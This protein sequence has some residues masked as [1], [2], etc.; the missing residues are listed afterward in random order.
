LLDEYLAANTTPGGVEP[1]EKLQ[2]LIYAGDV[3]VRLVEDHFTSDL[4]KF[5]SAMP[6][7]RQVALI[8][9]RS[10]MKSAHDHLGKDRTAEALDTYTSARKIF[11][12]NGDAPEA[13][14][15]RYTSAYA[16]LLQSESNESLSDFEYVSREAEAKR[17]RWFLGQSLNGLGN[18]NIGFNNYSLAL[19]LCQ[20]SLKILE[21]VGD[22]VGIVKVNDQLGSVYFRL[23]NRKEAL[24]F[25]HDAIT[26]ATENSLGTGPL[27]RTY[28]LAAVT[29]H[30]VGL[31][32]AGIDLTKESL[33]F[34][35]S[36]NA[37][38]S[39]SRS[40]AQLGVMY[41][42]RGNYPEAASSIERATE[43]GKQVETERVRINAVGYAAL[44]MGNLY[45][46]EGEYSRATESYDEAIRLFDQLNFSAFSYVAHKGKF[47]SCVAQRG[48]CLS[49][50]EELATAL[51]LYEA[52]RSKIVETRNRYSF[53]DTEQGV[54]DVAIDYEFTSKN[55]KAKAFDYSERCRARSLL[56]PPDANSRQAHHPTGD[57]T[58]V[59]PGGL[60][61]IQKAITDKD[62]IVQYA[63]L[64]DKLLIWFVSH[65]RFEAFQQP[66]SAN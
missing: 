62:Q 49:I 26:L 23:G 7:S 40:Y 56:D 33:R 63:V 28:F 54:Y 29:F 53:F 32:A 3:G 59:E 52:H 48:G 18:V 60:D 47:L 35:E 46:L 17:Y 51:S 19:E 42:S 45:R 22:I 37:H 66:I 44:Q 65:N 30:G 12:E 34:A 50:E 10:L 36:N 39:V 57:S 9:A 27:W 55:D 24:R 14:V 15:C 1:R 41:G 61:D 4:A 25:H 2:A 11:E 13:L 38:L 6:R 58:P 20:R 16:H 43:S 64:A 8:E 5:Y 21:E 31:T